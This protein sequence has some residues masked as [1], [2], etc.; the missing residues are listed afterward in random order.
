MRKMLFAS[1]ALCAVVLFSML[2]MPEVSAEVLAY[3][4]GG[5]LTCQDPISGKVFCR[6][7]WSLDGY[8][9][10]RIE[11]RGWFYTYFALAQ[12]YSVSVWIC[13]KVGWWIFSWWT[14]SGNWQPNRAFWNTMRVGPETFYYSKNF[15]DVN[16]ANLKEYQIN[17][18]TQFAGIAWNTRSSATVYWQ[19]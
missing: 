11:F 3:S 9:N 2:Y 19:L 18:Q 10:N 5:T 7:Y 14:D 13:E 15:Y 16:T 8:P 4:A 1:L 6:L 17:V 12:E